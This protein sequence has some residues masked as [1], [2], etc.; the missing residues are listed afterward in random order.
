[1]AKADARPQSKNERAGAAVSKAV[2][3]APAA[4]LTTA[5]VVGS[6]VVIV[7]SLSVVNAASKYAAAR[8]AFA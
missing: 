1:M 3:L 7:S 5:G 6:F 4:G 2:A 8:S